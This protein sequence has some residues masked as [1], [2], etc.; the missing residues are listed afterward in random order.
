MI[1]TTQI[2]KKLCNKRSWINNL[3]ISQTQILFTMKHKIKCWSY[4]IMLFLLNESKNDS[5]K[6]KKRQERDKKGCK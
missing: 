2:M 5:S 4:E 3:Q 1:N 6:C